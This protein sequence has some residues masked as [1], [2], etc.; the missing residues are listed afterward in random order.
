L[1]QLIAVKEETLYYLDE[2]KAQQNSAILKL[3]CP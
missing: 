3:P 1:Y 2:D